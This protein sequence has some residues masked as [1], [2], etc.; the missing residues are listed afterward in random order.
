MARVRAMYI[1]YYTQ[2]VL[3]FF[4]YN[5]NYTLKNINLLIKNAITKNNNKFFA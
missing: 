4:E 3:I 2:C 5:K 1:F